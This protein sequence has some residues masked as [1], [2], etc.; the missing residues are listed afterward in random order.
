[1]CFPQSNLVL[2]VAWWQII[3]II[4]IS[5]TSYSIWLL[6]FIFKNSFTLARLYI[7]NSN[8]V[9][10]AA[11]TNIV[12]IW[13]IANWSY[14]IVVSFK[15]SFAFLCFYTPNLKCFYVARRNVFSIR[16]KHDFINAVL[17]SF[18]SVNLVS[19]F[20]IPHSNKL[21]MAARTHIFIIRRPIYT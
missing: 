1:M 10:L 4:R 20:H 2:K 7:P 6:R 14:D 17:T 18:E 11:R 9:I 16:G 21:I 5:N 13:W 15:N 8:G 12:S 3:A 19:W